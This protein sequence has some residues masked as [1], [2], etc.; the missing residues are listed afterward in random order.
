MFG[1]FKRKHSKRTLPIHYLV[2]NA[3][4]SIRWDGIYITENLKKL[5]GLEAQIGQ[6]F[7][8]IRNSILH[9]GSRGTYLPHHYFKIHKSNRVVFTWFHG[10][11]NDHK[12]IQSL[13]KG[14]E[15]A[16]FVHTSCLI[17]RN[18]LLEW[19]VSESKIKVIPLGVDNQLFHALE[20]SDKRLRRKQLGIPEDA[21]V[22]GSFQKDGNGWEE[23]MSPKLIKGPDIFCEVVRQLH[24]NYPIFVLLTGPARGYVKS[25]LTKQNIRFKHIYLSDYRE[26]ANYFNLL[27]LYIIASRAEGGPKAILESMASGV[28]VVSTKVGMAPD[29]II[30]GENGFLADI[31]DISTLVRLSEKVIDSKELSSKFV[32]SG[33]ALAKEYDWPIITQQYYEQI[34]SEIL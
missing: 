22:L 26:V 4:W 12:F 15:K 3:D 9:F 19:G 8:H 23:G 27:D 17:S 6:K 7:S 32:R 25:Q 21:V 31:E 29:I 28:P 10:T 33:I 30:S 20:S 16:D 14:A 11:Q 34:Y 1:W 18:Q 24:R 2:E 13:P 5:Y